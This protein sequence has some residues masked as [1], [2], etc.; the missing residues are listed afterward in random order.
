MYRLSLNR[1]VPVCCYLMIT[2]GFAN[3][4]FAQQPPV[5]PEFDRIVQNFVAENTARSVVVAD[6]NLITLGIMDFNPSE[7][8]DTGDLDVGNEDTL[9]LRSSLTNYSLPWSFA[10]QQLSEQLSYQTKLRASYIGVKQNFQL[11]QE[12]GINPLDEKNYLVYGENA[13]RYQATPNWTIHFGV[14]LQYLF[15]HNNFDYQTPTMTAL[16][17][18]FERRLLNTSYSALLLDPSV[19]VRYRGQLGEHHWQ[20]QAEYRYALGHT[21]TSDY[22]AQETHMQA[23]RLSNTVILHYQTGTLWQRPNQLRVL[24]RRI[25]I[26]HDAIT[27]LGT[28]HYY[29]FGL[30]WIVDTSKDSSLLDSIGIGISLN[31]GSD[32]SGGSVVLLFN[33]DL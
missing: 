29:E 20:Y 16:K 22:R 18:T 9:E 31:I 7:F 24:A 21:I 3:N 1:L 4:S 5:S 26:D 30:G 33:E 10:R 28:S 27:P 19:G 23:G 2:V 13:W 15:Y 6:A 8:I 14:G 32:L 17:P 25:D 11:E 12:D